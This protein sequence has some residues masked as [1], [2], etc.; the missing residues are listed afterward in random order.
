LVAFA[1]LLDLIFNA[2]PLFYTFQFL[3]WLSSFCIGEIHPWGIFELIIRM[4]I[5]TG[6]GD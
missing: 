1:S 3:S 6:K 2:I 5:E 4:C